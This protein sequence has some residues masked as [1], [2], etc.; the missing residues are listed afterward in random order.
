M[1]LSKYFNTKFFYRIV[2]LIF[3]LFLFF[4][5]NADQLTS[6]QSTGHTLTTSTNEK[7]IVI[8]MPLKVKG[9]KD[10]EF[11]AGLPDKVKVRIIGPS[12]IVTAINNTRNFE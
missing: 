10:T 6:G 8:E 4:Y 12:A 9:A 1:K 5:V 2:A 11:V 3:A 7:S